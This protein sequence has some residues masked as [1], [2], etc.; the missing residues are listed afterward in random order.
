MQK[1]PF[2]P[3]PGEILICDYSSGFRAP[4]MIKRRLCVVV[5][6]KLKRRDDLV[7][8]VPLSETAPEPAEDWHHQYQLVSQSWGNGP[9]WAKCDMIATVSYERLSRPYYRHPVTGTRLFETLAIPADDL[10]EIRRKVALALG[11]NLA[12]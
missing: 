9:R 10:N 12:N 11:L 3:R 7:S 2:H 5:S 6:P 8:V 1:L 4:E